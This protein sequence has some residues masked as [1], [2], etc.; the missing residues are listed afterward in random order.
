M[1]VNVNVNWAEILD[2][3]TGKKNIYVQFTDKF[4]VIYVKK[5]ST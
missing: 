3:F 1:T 4:P 5:I 2:Y